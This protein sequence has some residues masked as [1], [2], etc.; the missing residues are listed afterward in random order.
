MSLLW[1]PK[2]DWWSF[3]YIDLWWT[4]EI[5]TKLI[6]KDSALKNILKSCDEGA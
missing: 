1:N 4:N 5:D 2:P 3:N 6:S